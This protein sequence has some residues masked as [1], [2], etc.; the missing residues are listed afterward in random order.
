MKQ[1][2][3]EIVKRK[4]DNKGDFYTNF[5]FAASDYIRE[6]AFFCSGKTSNVKRKQQ[7]A[8]KELSFISR[9]LDKEYGIP[10]I[11]GQFAFSDVARN[12]ELIIYALD[13]ITKNVEI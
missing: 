10:I 4:R 13:I 12:H 5:L 8:M 2:L 1:R 11:E 9:S 3:E 6:L 7:L